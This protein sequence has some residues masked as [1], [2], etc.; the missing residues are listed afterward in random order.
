M[1]KSVVVLL[2]LIWIALSG[3]ALAADSLT[4][5][6][7]PGAKAEQAKAITD[8]LSAG[9]GITI[10][11]QV[12]KSYPE[13][14]AA[15]ST[16]KPQLVYVGSFVQAIIA[17]RKLGTPLVQNANGKEMYSGILIYPAGQDPEAI[18][19]SSP[20]EIAFALGASS[21]ESTAK[22]ATAG[23]AALGVANH[24]AAVKA[25]LDGK[26][27]AAVVKDWWWLGNEKNYSGLKSYRIPGLSEQKNPDNVLTAS[28]AVSQDAMDKITMAALGASAAFG[29]KSVVLPFDPSQ[30]S[31]SLGLMKKGNIDPLTYSW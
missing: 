1:K 24:G 18:L 5:W 17:A 20:A 26:A 11:P 14:L 8:A 2:T 27:K 16:D 22:A 15:F 31:F 30:V 25:V 10:T 6:F 7:S 23:K 28:K 9:S 4:C 13:I 12:A 21:G 3:A 29:D 19:K